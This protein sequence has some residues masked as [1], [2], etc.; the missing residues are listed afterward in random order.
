MENEDLVE[1]EGFEEEDNCGKGRKKAKPGRKRVAIPEDV[2]EKLQKARRVWMKCFRIDLLKAD[3]EE[4]QSLIPPTDVTKPQEI[5]QTQKEMQEEVDA[6]D[7]EQIE[8]LKTVTGGIK[9]KQTHW[10]KTMDRYSKVMD[11]YEPQQAMSQ[12]RSSF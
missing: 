2:V 6:A 5:A 10:E 3:D 8:E 9:E 1:Q 12:K 4:I 11:A 7:R